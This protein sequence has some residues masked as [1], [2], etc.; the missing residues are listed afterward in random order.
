MIVFMIIDCCPINASRAGHRRGAAL[1]LLL[2]ALLASAVNSRAGDLT[3][4]QYNN[5]GLKVDLG[6]GLWA[7]PVPIDFNGDGKLDLVV[8]CPDT[9]FNGAWFFENTG[10]NPKMP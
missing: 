10:G 5:P 8:V 3:R 4:L 1:R 2:V 9:P 6:V 7:W